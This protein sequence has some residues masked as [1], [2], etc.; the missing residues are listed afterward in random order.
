MQ[1][2][3][4]VSLLAGRSFLFELA[5]TQ[6]VSGGICKSAQRSLERSLKSRL[7]NK[8]NPLRVFAS[9]HQKI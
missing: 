7:C 2:K 1:K 9:T 4:P 6:T 3:T 8:S 5:R